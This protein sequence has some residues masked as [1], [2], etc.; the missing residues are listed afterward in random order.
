[1]DREEAIND[2]IVQTKKKLVKANASFKSSQSRNSRHSSTTTLKSSLSST[3]SGTKP[4]KHHKP[5]AKRQQS[6][7]SRHSRED[8]ATNASLKRSN[9]QDIRLGKKTS[10]KDLKTQNEAADLRK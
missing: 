10:A 5:Q 3:L 7:Y 9:T 2:S 1:V 6:S 8:T 4:R